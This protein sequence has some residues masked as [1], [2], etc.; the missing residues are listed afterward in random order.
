MLDTL[1]PVTAPSSLLNAVALD[2]LKA[3]VKFA[4][5]PLLSATERAP[6]ARAAPVFL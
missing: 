3:L 5:D 6:L 4:E 2:T 1:L